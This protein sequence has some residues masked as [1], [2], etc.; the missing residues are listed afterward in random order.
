MDTGHLQEHPI[1]P[2]SPVSPALMLA[3]LFLAFAALLT[4]AYVYAQAQAANGV[5]EGT[6]TDPSGSVVAGAKVRITNLDTG[7]AR[8]VTTSDS[9]FYRAPLLPLG[10]YEVVVE[11]SGF[12]RFSQSGI[13]LS[14]G[15]AA[16]IDIGLKVGAVSNEVTI[17]S[18]APIAD[19]SKIELGRTISQ[20]EVQNLPLPS[21]NPYNFGLLQPGING[22][23]NVEFGVPRFNANGYKSRINYQLDGSTNTQKDRAG[24]RLSP[25]SEVFVREVQVVSNGFAPEF[26]QTSGVV[27]NAIT[28]SGTNKF[29]GTGAYFLRRTSFVA[30]PF[31]LRPDIAKADPGLDNPIGSLGG[32]LV[33]D[34]AHFYIGYEYVKRQLQQDRVVTVT[35]A[36]ATA[37]GLPTPVG[38]IP[39]SQK[40]NFFIVRPDW[41]IGNSNE[42]FGRYTLFKNNS[43]NNIGGGLNTLQRSIDFTDNIQIINGQVISIISQNL[44]NELRLQYSRRNQPNVL[45]SNSGTGPSV[46]VSG[47]AQFGAP[48]PG[49]GPNLLNQRNTQIVDNMTWTRG[50]H[51]FKGGVDAQFIRDRRIVALTPTYTFASI[52]TYLDARSGVNTRSYA[53][54]AQIAGEPKIEYNTEFYSLFFQDDWR[55][56]PNL[57]VTYGLRYEMY[58]V[59]KARGNAPLDISRKFNRDTNNFAP[60]LGLAYSFGSFGGRKTVIRA[61]A[62]IFYDAPGLLFYQNAI[63]NNGDPL[64]RS[65]SLRPTDPGS[66]AFPNSATLTGVAPPKVSIDAIS[67]SFANLY[68]FNQNLQIEQE[69]GKDFSVTAGYVHVRGN[70]I[71]VVRRTN[72]PPITGT[73]GDGRAIFGTAA[74]PN[75]DFNNIDITESVGQS[76]YNAGSLTLNKRFSHGVQMSASY[77]L[78]HGID[79]APEINIID[80]TEFPSDPTNRRR[81]RANS[82]A[83]QRHTFIASSVINPQFKLSNGFA[84]AIFNGNQIGIIARANTGFR[85]NVRGNRDLNGDGVA[86]NDRPLFGGRNTQTTGNVRQLDLRYSRFIP[87]HEAMRIEIIGEFTNLFNILNI[88]S[89]NAV[90]PVN[91]D[92]TLVTPTSTSAP[93]ILTATDKRQV[94]TGGFPQ[95]IFQLGF[96][97]HF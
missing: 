17:T 19:T 13:T 28:P 4:P 75:T 83:D 86:T 76:V 33:K 15:Q 36:N 58:D 63:Q 45:N 48:A 87:I 8:E 7:T 70:R 71:P 72:L 26:G 61:S 32:P 55:V 50:N 14:A 79:D 42:V 10:R 93:N 74:R 56:K 24:L 30:R 16:T 78:S 57:K 94:A 92:G 9:G 68:S 12:N 21:R 18:D 27:Y 60:R 62:G 59:P 77:T 95:R 97:F 2:A 40:T 53:T 88:S 81:D 89:V 31:F 84:N 20:T 69:L 29:H 73:L 6:V 90:V 91:T 66:P 52:Q 64:T 39:A 46:T 25:I 49:D 38:F 37:L 43:P 1:R 85:V 44:V 5:I 51:S 65:F 54:F 35:T 67:P 22:F 80:S 23:E 3:S 96:K 41:K 11:Q 34:K 82:L 47:I